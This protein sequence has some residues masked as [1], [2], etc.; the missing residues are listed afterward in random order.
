MMSPDN[1]QPAGDASS[2]PITVRVEHDGR[3]RWSVAMPDQSRAVSCE[4]LDDARRVAYQCAA[5]SRPCELIVHD[6]YH[7]VLQRELINGHR[8]LRAS[9]P[10]AAATQPTHQG[11]R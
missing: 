7:R 9:P 1:G 10:T 3:G 2:D 11:G 8:D 4:T 6:A 5:R